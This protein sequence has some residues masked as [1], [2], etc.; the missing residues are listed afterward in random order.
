MTRQL[1]HLCNFDPGSE[2][3]HKMS[4]KC[5]ELFSVEGSPVLLPLQES[6]TTKV[7]PASASTNTNRP[8]EIPLLTI[9]G[10]LDDIIIMPSLQK[11][12]KIGMVANDG[13]IFHFLCKPKDDLR[14]DARL[15]DF[16]SVINKLLR[17]S[18]ESRRR[19]LRGLFTSWLS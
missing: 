1:L 14:K 6:F 16:N 10:F 17:A 15:S 18:S 7:P 2:E 12:R 5:L 8:F 3:R 11:P 4:V 9:A 19:Q 13:Q